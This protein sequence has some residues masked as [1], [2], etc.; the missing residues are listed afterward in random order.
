MEVDRIRARPAV[1]KVRAAVAIDGVGARPET[2]GIA[3]GRTHDGKG[4]RNGRRPYAGDIGDDRR[5]RNILIGGIRQVQVDGGVEI[6][7]LISTGSAGDRHFRAVVVQKIAGGIADDDVRAAAAV[8][9]IGEAVA[10]NDRV[11]ARRSHDGHGEVDVRRI[12]VR[13][14][15]DVRR[16]ARR[17]IGGDGEIEVHGGVE[18]E[19]ADACAAIDGRFR[20]VIIDRVGAGTGVD[21]VATAVAI[22]GFAAGPA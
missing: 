11:A 14:V 19:R 20:T 17:L 8:D 18:H 10:A 4:G 16:A 5:S 13:D 2:D 7:T 3:A 15:R 21:D 9:G 1:D 6:Q 12:D 22:D